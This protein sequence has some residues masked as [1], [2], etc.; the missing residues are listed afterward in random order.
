[1]ENVIHNCSILGNCSLGYP[2]IGVYSSANEPYEKSG[3]ME[4]VS[5]AGVILLSLVLAGRKAMS[6]LRIMNERNNISHSEKQG[7]EV[8]LYNVTHTSEN[9]S[10]V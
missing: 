3:F 10:E 5:L 4:S 6:W 9:I 7:G 8:I 1:M 2:E